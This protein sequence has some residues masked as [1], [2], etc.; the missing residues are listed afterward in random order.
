MSWIAITGVLFVINVLKASKILLIG[1]LLLMA[2]MIVT[3][4]VA[5]SVKSKVSDV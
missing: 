3:G 4:S 5:R 2:S 1:A